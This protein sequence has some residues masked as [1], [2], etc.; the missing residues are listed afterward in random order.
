MK[1]NTYAV[2]CNDAWLNTEG[3]DISGSYVKY[4]DHQDVMAELEAKCAALSIES[5]ERRQFILNGVEMGF[6]R[7]PDKDTR[8]PATA[9]YERCLNGIQYRPCPKCNDTGMA[10]SGGTQPWGEPIE[11]ECDCRQQDSNTAE[12]VAAGIITKVGE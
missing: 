12:L 2:N 6:I 3:D 9:T 5:E 8:D 4:K 11:I 7:L 1:I 10:D